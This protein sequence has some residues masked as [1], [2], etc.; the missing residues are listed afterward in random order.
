MQS[1]ETDKF[2]VDLCNLRVIW[3]GGQL[4]G[5]AEGIKPKCVAL[6]LQGGNWP[7]PRDKKDYHTSGL[8]DKDW[9]TH[10]TS[11]LVYWRGQKGRYSS[12][13]FR[14][15]QSGDTNLE[16]FHCEW[17]FNAM[18]HDDIT[19]LW[20]PGALKYFEDMFHFLPPFQ[21]LCSPKPCSKYRFN[22]HFQSNRLSANTCVVI[23]HAANGKGWLQREGSNAFKLVTL[24]L[25]NQ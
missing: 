3:K 9:S 21:P 8:R 15:V 2:R 12:V 20:T 1:W 19:E 7:L 11:D 25:A 22:T 13:A 24:S 14:E 18:R 10:Q 5:F 16:M 17:I 6:L 23:F 4:K